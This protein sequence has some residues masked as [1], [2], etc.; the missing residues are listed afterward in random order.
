MRSLI[1]MYLPNTTKLL[2]TN[3]PCKN[4]AISLLLMDILGASYFIINKK[5]YYTFDLL[6]AFKLTKPQDQ[7][8]RFQSPVLT[9]ANTEL[10]P[11][12]KI[13]KKHCIF[14]D[15]TGVCISYPLEGTKGVPQASPK[16]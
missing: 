16:S 12:K 11:P 3:F 1:Q 7:I 8:M 6:L 4:E 15:K 14:Q 10:P 5:L 2:D 9:L 13:K